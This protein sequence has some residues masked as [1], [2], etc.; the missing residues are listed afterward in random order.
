MLNFGRPIV[1]CTPKRL[2][3]FK[4][5][6]HKLEK[7]RHAWLPRMVARGPLESCWCGEAFCG[8][9]HKNQ[10]WTSITGTNEGRRR[11]QYANINRVARITKRAYVHL[12]YHGRAPLDS[13]QVLASHRPFGHPKFRCFS[14]QIPIVTL[15][16]D[17]ENLEL[18]TKLLWPNNIWS[19]AF[20]HT[21]NKF[22]YSLTIE[23]HYTFLFFI[24][25][26]FIHQIRTLEFEYLSTEY[27]CRVT[28]FAG[29][30]LARSGW[31]NGR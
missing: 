13:C 4:N 28:V 11:K 15:R 17:P 20:G 25:I 2:I 18:L 26:F 3:L 12:P 6:G 27:L 24:K 29:A 19:I 10:L 7:C 5:L 30:S 9:V 1:K 23:L 31:P 8:K 14:Y 16:L 21:C 22:T